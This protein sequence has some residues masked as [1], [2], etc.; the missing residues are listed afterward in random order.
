MREKS[1]DSQSRRR[2]RA[3]QAEPREGV[4]AY[5]ERAAVAR[6]REGH[7][8]VKLGIRITLSRN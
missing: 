8:G 6:E 3:E 5:G 4:V 2:R 7:R 1:R